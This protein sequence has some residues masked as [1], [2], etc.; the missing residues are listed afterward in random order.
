MV[1]SS[2]S[3]SYQHTIVQIAANQTISQS[4]HIFFKAIFA[5]LDY[6]CNVFQ[7]GYGILEKQPSSQAL[8]NQQPFR[9]HFFRTVIS[10]R[11]TTTSP[12]GSSTFLHHLMRRISIAF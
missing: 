7:S 5:N 9:N 3:K 2:P 12:V 1:D 10:N 8:G 11:G 4:T 6:M